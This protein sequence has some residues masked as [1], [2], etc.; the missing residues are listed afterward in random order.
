[1]IIDFDN[2]ERPVVFSYGHEPQE[3]LGFDA[4][5]LVIVHGT[6]RGH[7]HSDLQST[8]TSSNDITR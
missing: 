5:T 4:V 6:L 8:P 7:N 3:T 2:S 1:M